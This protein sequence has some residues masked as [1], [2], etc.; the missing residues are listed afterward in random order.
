VLGAPER[1]V[2]VADARHVQ[3][4]ALAQRVESLTPAQRAELA[5]ILRQRRADASTAIPRRG[6]SGPAPLSFSQE[7]LWFL[8]QWDPGA[9]TN[10]GVRAVRL[11][12]TLDVNA[13]HSALGTVVERHESLRT[14]YLVRNRRPEQ[15]ALDDWALDLPVVDLAQLEAVEREQELVRRLRA[16]SRKPFDLETDLMIRSVLFRLGPSEHVLLLSLHHI[17]AD[18]WSAGV[19]N[20]DLAEAYAA[21]ASGLEPALAELPLQY[22]DYAVWQREHLQGATLDALLAYWRRELDGAPARLR[23]PIDRTRPPVQM[24]RGRHLEVSYDGDQGTAVARLAREEGATTYMALLAAFA[25]LL[26]R[27]SGQDDVLVGTPVA[28]RAH[29]ELENL[30]GL[31]SNTLVMRS[32]LAGNPTFRELV[33]RV[34]KTA[35]GA[36][37]HQELPFEKLV[38]ALRIDRDPAYNPL[39]QVN[40]RANAAPGAGLQLQGLDATPLS[41]DIGFSRFDLALELELGGGRVGGYFEY[42]EELFD[43]ATIEALESDFGSLLAAIASDPDRPILTL[44]PSARR[45][46]DSSRTISRTAH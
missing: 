42:D 44:A 27:F 38:E 22:A 34:R 29:V 16:E 21:H 10:H 3:E 6:G 12:G 7:S 31:F 15:V 46:S 26:Y 41:V 9:P 4:R 19:L 35:V 2:P 33:Q 14:V 18:G 45:P 5:Q 1:R 30:I 24:H 37:A 32:R 28:N 23:L 13:M 39:F 25:T 43:P 17:A 11:R 8:E 40:F 36:Y 20:R